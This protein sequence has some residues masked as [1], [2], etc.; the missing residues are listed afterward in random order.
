MHRH[1]RYTVVACRAV[2]VR[3]ECNLVQKAR[4]RR[5]LRTVFE[6]RQDVRFE[7]LYVFEPPAALHV[8]LLLKGAHIARLLADRV[9]ELRKR[10]RVR[11]L[12]QIL[13]EPGEALQLAR[14]ALEHRVLPRR[15]QDLD[16]R[17]ALLARKALHALDG[18]IADAARRVVDDAA[19][20][21]IV[22]RVIDD[23]EVGKHIL[24]LRTLEELC[25][26]HDLIRH[27]VAL[28]RIFKRIR[29]RIHAVQNGVVFPRPP[30]VV[31]HHDAA[32][33]E[34]CLVLLIENGLD[35]NALARA[36]VGPQG[37]PLASGIILDDGVRRVEDILRGAVIL[38]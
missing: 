19:Q 31:L 23:R 12:A 7:L 22:A 33:D 24:D 3:I 11:Q 16:H 18:R 2:K 34:I 20:A 14:G 5:V 15:A 35:E 17:H 6:E 4:E 25:S 38:L 27:A 8:V 28:E 36:R 30:A 26:S 13:D 37:L 21:Q 9:V 1:H 29:L 10:H 32:D